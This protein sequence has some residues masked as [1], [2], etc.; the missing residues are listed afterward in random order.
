MFGRNDLPAYIMEAKDRCVDYIILLGNAGMLLFKGCTLVLF[1]TGWS[2]IDVN[3]E[4]GGK[5]SF[6]YHINEGVYSSFGSVI[7]SSACP[8]PVLLKKPSPDLPLHSSSFWGPTGDG[9]D[10]V[11]EGLELPELHV[12]DWLLFENMGAHTVPAA[13]SL[14]GGQQAQIHYALSR[15]AWEAVQLLKGK[16]LHA[17]E[18]DGRESAC[19]PLSCGWEITDTLCVAPVFAPA[20]I[21]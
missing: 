17:E 18:E 14:R 7:F 3:E 13:T 21:M 1:L 6:I 10:R 11:A 20:S 12:G 16:P 9:L 5:K 15:M 19:A 2:A 4:P 8:T